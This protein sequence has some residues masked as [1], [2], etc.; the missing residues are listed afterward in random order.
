MAARVA[1][2]RQQTP[3]TT[4]VVTFNS[5][6]GWGK[7]DAVIFFVSSSDAADGTADATGRL[8]IGFTDGTNYRCNSFVVR[9]IETD[10]SYSFRHQADDAVACLLS[11]TTA[12]TPFQYGV[13]QAKASWPTDGVDVDWTVNAGGQYYLVAVMFY[14]CGGTEV[15]THTPATAIDGTKAQGSMGFAPDLVFMTCTGQRA[16]DAEGIAGTSLSHAIFNFGCAERTDNRLRCCFFNSVDGVDLTST[17]TVVNNYAD[18]SYMAGQ[19]HND[20]STWRL[21]IDGMQADSP[22][23]PR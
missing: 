20:A 2:D 11:S 3:A 13:P 4:G 19:T 9:D 7:P 1:I 22:A 21:G 6:S 15:G 18:T 10:L 14:D 23:L 16:I 17:T 5:P 8:S 12:T